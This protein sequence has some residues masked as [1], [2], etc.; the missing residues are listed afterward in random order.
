MQQKRNWKGP[1][2]HNLLWR[3][4]PKDLKTSAGKLLIKVLSP[5]KRTAS[6]T[7]A[8][9]GRPLEEVQNPVYSMPLRFHCL[10]HKQTDC[11]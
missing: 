5:P 3:H 8:L 4:G 1:A 7:N 9:P 2:F 10:F 11:F 6:R